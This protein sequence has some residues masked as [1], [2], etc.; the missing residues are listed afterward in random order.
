ML[1]PASPA[2][3]YTGAAWV[4]H[5]L[6]L[7]GMLWHGGE[8]F[9]L[10]KTLFTYSTLPQMANAPGGVCVGTSSVRPLGEV[11]RSDRYNYRAK[12]CS[13]ERS[14][15]LARKSNPVEK[16]KKGGLCAKP[17]CQKHLCLHRTA[18]FIFHPKREHPIH[19]EKQ[20]DGCRAQIERHRPPCVCV[21]A[22]KQAMRQRHQKHGI[23]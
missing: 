10:T 9:T 12:T 16:Q 14:D 6:L 4:K 17:A 15:L 7:T 3:A 23:A 21:C 8:C 2:W 22:G 11:Y 19:R 18:R 20:G 5:S 13:N 1:R